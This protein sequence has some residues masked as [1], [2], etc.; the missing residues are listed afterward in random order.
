MRTSALYATLIVA[1]VLIPAFFME[2][3]AGA[4][5]PPAAIAYLLAVGASMLVA[6][7]V[8]PALA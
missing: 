1:A 4:F 5:L 2:A 3:E 7:T 6:L 8:T